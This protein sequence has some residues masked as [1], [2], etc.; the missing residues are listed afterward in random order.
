M[1]VLSKP[2]RQVGIATGLGTEKILTDSIC[3][4]VLKTTMIPRFKDDMYYE[5]IAQ[6]LDSLINKWEDF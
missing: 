2:L 5:G 1:I 6:G 3:K 4:Q